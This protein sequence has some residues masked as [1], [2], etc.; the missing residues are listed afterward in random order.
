MLVADDAFGELLRHGKGRIEP[1]AMDQS[2]GSYKQ[3][4]HARIESWWE[5]ARVGSPDKRQGLGLRHRVA[6]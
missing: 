6:P 5:F 1:Q 2:I 4:A 3:P